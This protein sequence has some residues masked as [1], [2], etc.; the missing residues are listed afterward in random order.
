M[1][2]KEKNF[3]EMSLMEL[4]AEEPPEEEDVP[5]SAWIIEIGDRLLNFTGTGD[6]QKELEDEID[7]L[8]QEIKRL[9]RHYHINNRV[10]CEIK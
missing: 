9:K 7:G 10:V 2:T 4:I 5:Y 3:N 8:K 6:R 1:S